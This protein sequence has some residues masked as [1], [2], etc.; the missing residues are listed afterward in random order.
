MKDKSHD[1]TLSIKE[2][3]EFLIVNERESAQKRTTTSS[4]SPSSSFKPLPVPVFDDLDDDEFAS[5]LNTIFQ[6]A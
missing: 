6:S 2:D 4:P 3:S 5:V 1:P